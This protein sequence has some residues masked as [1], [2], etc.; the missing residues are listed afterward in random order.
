MDLRYLAFMRARFMNSASL[1]SNSNVRIEPQ[2]SPF[3][4]W[5]VSLKRFEDCHLSRVLSSAPTFSSATDVGAPKALST[6]ARMRAK[7]ASQV[8]LASSGELP[9]GRT[10][11]SPTAAVRDRRGVERE[12]GRS[13]R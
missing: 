7:S 6:S 2:L 13:V 10:K 9:G 8:A 5:L 11:S 12:R 3:T 4:Y 1:P